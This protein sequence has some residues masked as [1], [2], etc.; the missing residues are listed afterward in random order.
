MTKETKHM[1]YWIIAY[2]IWLENKA[3]KQNGE[4]KK[5]I[6]NNYQNNTNLF[7]QVNQYSGPKDDF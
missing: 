6:E 1:R 5:G 7:C 3:S 4:V 2:S